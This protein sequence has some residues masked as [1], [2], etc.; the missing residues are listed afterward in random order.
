MRSD[1]VIIPDRG[2]RI[3]NWAGRLVALGPGEKCLVVAV[4]CRQRLAAQSVWRRRQRGSFPS[5][6]V[7]A[8]DTDA[9]P[10]V[11]GNVLIARSGILVSVHALRADNVRA[12]PLFTLLLQLS[13]ASLP[14]R[15]AG[16]GA[17]S[18][19]AFGRRKV[20]TPILDDA[21]TLLA[22]SC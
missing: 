9:D 4:A 6:V 19:D 11:A 12:V 22:P 2:G 15:L 17:V 21:A 14:V 1:A 13:L 18:G 3:A 5:L 20:R 10:L 16:A 8:G 7:A